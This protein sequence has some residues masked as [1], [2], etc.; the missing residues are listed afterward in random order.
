MPALPSGIELLRPG[1]G[2]R[3]PASGW[4]SRV[5]TGIDSVVNRCRSSPQSTPQATL[6]PNRCSA[7]RAIPMR[8]SRV[9]SR[10]PLIRPA[11]ASARSASETSSATDGAGM[12]PMIVISSRSSEHLRRTLEP[13]LGES[14]GEPATQLLGGLSRCPCHATMITPLHASSQ[15]PQRLFATSGAPCRIAAARRRASGIEPEARL[16]REACFRRVTLR[17]WLAA[18]WSCSCSRCS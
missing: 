12:R 11:I 3:E 14:A 8:A 17:R 15:G 18:R 13:V 1:R 7:S 4:R 16:R 9:S 10:K 5:M 2:C 6:R